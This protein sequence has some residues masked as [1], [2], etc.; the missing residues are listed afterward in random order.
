MHFDSVFYSF[1][2]YTDG[3]V[4]IKGQGFSV[5]KARAAT[6]TDFNYTG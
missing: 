5:W 4:I 6:Q 3:S 2:I 1:K